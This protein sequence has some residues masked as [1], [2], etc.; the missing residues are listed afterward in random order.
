MKVAS[1]TRRRMRRVSLRLLILPRNCGGL[2]PSPYSVSSLSFCSEVGRPFFAAKTHNWSQSEWPK[3]CDAKCDAMRCKLRKIKRCKS[4]EVPFASWRLLFLSVG[5]G[6]WKTVISGL[7][8]KKNGWQH[9]AMPT[10]YAS[11]HDSWCDAMQSPAMYILRPT[12]TSDAAMR[13]EIT[14]QCPWFGPLR[15]QYGI[16]PEWGRAKRSCSKFR[17]LREVAFRS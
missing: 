1:T 12:W 14:M 5:F 13:G 4:E 7:E 16:L 2:P 6:R 15:S 3:S 11:K 9:R 10:G 8:Q 17:R